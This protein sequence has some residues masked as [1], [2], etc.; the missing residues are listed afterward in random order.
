[1]AQNCGHCV[2]GATVWNG[3]ADELI[4]A[5]LP[6]HEG[7]LSHV[8]AEACVNECRNFSA[9]REPVAQPP[10]PE[11]PD[12]SCRYVPL[13]RGYFALV[14]AADYERVMQYKWCA[15]SE[16]RGTV[17]GSCRPKGKT[18]LMH[19]LIMNAPPGKVVDHINGHG[20]DNRR[21]N[22]RLCDQMQNQWNLHTARGTSRFKGVSWSKQR[23]KWLATIRCRGKSMYLGLFAN[24]IDAARAYD[25]MASKLFG[26]YAHLNFTYPRRYVEL[27]GTI[28]VRSHA[29][30][31]LVV[32]RR[33]TMPAP[34]AG[35]APTHACHSDRRP[36]KPEWRNL[37]GKARAVSSVARWLD[38]AALRSP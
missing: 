16:H 36:K 15:T 22:L 37:A 14:D 29:E 7:V 12:A 18:L 19:R 30:G 3:T 27:S 35:M 13:T 10:M 38:S 26:E 2:R 23:R 6:G 34:S 21:D 32:I 1:M 28:H 24:E 11:P 17:Y 4:C 5:V 25:D 20:W 31:R 33:P 9:R 8:T